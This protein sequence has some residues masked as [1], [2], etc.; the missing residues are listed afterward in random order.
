MI[1]EGSILVKNARLFPVTGAE[2][3]PMLPGAEGGIVSAGGEL[4]PE[5]NLMRQYPPLRFKLDGKAPAPDDPDKPVFAMIRKTPSGDA[6]NRL[7][8]KYIFAGYLFD[9]FG[10]FLLESLS[11]LWF[12]KRYPDMPI[13]WLQANGPA[14]L[15][16]WQKD[17]L[18]AHG[19]DNPVHIISAPTDVEQLV[20][21]DDG[22]MIQTGFTEMHRD[23]LVL[24]DGQPPVAGKKI[25]M[26]RSKLDAGRYLNDI[27]LE[28]V[29][30]KAGWTIFHPQDHALEVQLDQVVDAERV[31]G[32]A[33]S[34]LHTLMF[35]RS[36]Q[37]RVDVFSRGRLLSQNFTRIAKVCGFNQFEHYVPGF[38][39][40]EQLPGWL[41]NYMWLS[42]EPVLDALDVAPSTERLVARP[43]LSA[44]L[45]K[46]SSAL[47]VGHAKPMDL[48]ALKG[49]VTQLIPAPEVRHAAQGQRIFTLTLEEAVLS[50]AVKGNSCDA[51]VVLDEAHCDVT[52]LSL[53]A[54]VLRREASLFL[55]AALSGLANQ[56]WPKALQVTVSLDGQHYIK[57][58]T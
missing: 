35:V 47:I 55:P 29:L 56:I 26:S 1:G 21:P 16:N 51:L 8:G 24:R 7:D 48:T 49:A 50:G 10:H 52:G 11:R 3:G 25:W 42:L 58:Q 44:E 9:H 20:I 39:W 17:M 12:I 43:D 54:T 36:L 33:G 57:V 46:A 13:V 2:D 23:A 40:S 28:G 19:I 22:F 6:T 15:G 4:V 45:A 14:R 27:Y 38:L 18:K 34:A 30:E 32:V 37:A 5:G 41:S 31:A 53:A